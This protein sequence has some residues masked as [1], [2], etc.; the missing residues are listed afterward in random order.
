M[1]N[2][3][4]VNHCVFVSPRL[5]AGIFVVVVGPNKNGG[6][7][8]FLDIYYGIL[9]PNVKACALGIERIGL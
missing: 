9:Q 4:L 6:R 7:W 2:N 1:S 5:F 3:E 8:M